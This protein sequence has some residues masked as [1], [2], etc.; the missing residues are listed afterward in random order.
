MTAPLYFGSL[1]H[2]WRF[3]SMLRGMISGFG[4]LR[5]VGMAFTGGAVVRF[6]FQSRGIVLEALTPIRAL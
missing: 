3:T 1:R 5:M 2:I 4:C 6:R